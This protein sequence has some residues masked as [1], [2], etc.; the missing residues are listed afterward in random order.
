MKD[1]F[2]RWLV[3]QKHMTNMAAKFNTG[4]KLFTVTNLWSAR[5]I[6]F[7]EVLSQYR[8]FRKEKKQ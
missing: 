3:E 2:E 8:K 5:E 6:T 4:S 1:A 7:D